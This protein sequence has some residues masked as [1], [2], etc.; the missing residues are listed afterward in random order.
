MAGSENGAERRVCAALLAHVDAGKTTLSEAM[1]YLSGR[2]KKP[3]RVDHGDSFLDTHALERERGITIFSKQAVLRAGA[4]SLTLLDTPGHVDFSSE[5]ERTL[6]VLDCAV[7]VISAPDGVQAHTETLWQL[8]ERYG[9]P[10]FIFVTK[11]DL[12]PDRAEAVLD[13]LRSRLSE[14]CAAFTPEP[15][16][17]ELALCSEALLDAH[18]AGEISDADISAAIARRE[19]FPCFFGSG[20][21]M[22]GVEELLNGLERFAPSPEYGG[23]FGAKVFK[24]MRDAQGARLTFMK[25]TGG[26]LSVRQSVEYVLDGER[27]SEKISQIR[28]YSGAKFEAVSEAGPGAVCAVTGLSGALHGQGLGA[29]AD[30]P[31]PVLEPVLTYRLTLPKGTDPM[32][33]LP[34]LRQLQEED[35]Q[36]HIVWIELLREIHLQLM[37]RVQIDVIKQL[38]SERFG[39]DVGVDDGRISYRETIAAPVEGV[40]HFEPLRHY[41]EVHLLLSPL[42]RGAGLVFDSEC[43]TDELDINWQRLILTHLAERRHL[44]VLTGSPITDM[45]ISLR[46]GRAHVKHTEGGDFRQA[47]YR[48]VRQGLMKAESVLLEPWYSFEIETPAELIGRAI[49]DVRAMSGEFDGPHDRGGRAYISG[50]APVSEMR[51]YAAELAAWSGGR[52]RLLCRVDGYRPCHEQ[53]KAVRERAYEPERDIENTPDSV[54][55]AHGGGFT[56]KWDKVSEYMHL[57]SCLAPE[58]EAAARPLRQI[59]ID[60]RELE[61]I[62]LREFGPVRRPMYRAPGVSDMRDAALN[63]APEKKSCV[64]VDGYNLIFAWDELNAL[65]RENLDAARVRLMDLLSSYRGFTG[66]ELVLVFD[67]YRVPGGAGV[68]A[69]YHGIHVVYTKQ[70][71]TG[72]AYIERLSH[73]IGR[74]F[75]VRVVTSDALI[76]LSAL[77]SGVLRVS[78]REFRAELDWAAGQIERLLK[79]SGERAH[80]ARVSESARLTKKEKSDGK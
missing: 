74:N 32:T 34:K 55:C 8:L 66:C 40:G 9:V 3:G 50:A 43:S 31:L 13:E 12:A 48:A 57:E 36:L 44:G 30:S 7:L 38:I 49:S 71:E 45:R 19:L 10:V 52:G 63:A 60:E 39:L 46:S 72:D 18:L 64:I 65:A 33:A 54:F 1:L 15:D 51:G 75:A 47:V 42:P 28:I 29:Q 61:E 17:E 21:K 20:L 4:L 73:D 76:Q 70:G 14:R 67:A 16:A 27:V 59:S 23:D 37:G 26:S 35:P 69:D 6:S 80:T 78:S 41:A 11:L 79:K 56:V 62:M 2:I 58:R 5:M 24:I 25:I 53:E 68:K 77:R 22:Q